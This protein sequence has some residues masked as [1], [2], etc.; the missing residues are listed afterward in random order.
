M[1]TSKIWREVSGSVAAE[2]GLTA[3]YF[4]V[5]VFGIVNAGLLLWTQLGLQHGVEMAA[6]CGSVNTTLCP[7]NDAIKTYA[8]T[9]T[10]GFPVS[11]SNF[12]IAPGDCG[13][14][15]VSGNY[16]YNIFGFVKWGGTPL[17]SINLSAQSCFPK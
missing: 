7:D 11:A 13:G 8:G 12:T 3:P 17:V 4:L 10:L 15:Q 2:F 6:R 16:P 14:I 5:A 1:K 9:Q